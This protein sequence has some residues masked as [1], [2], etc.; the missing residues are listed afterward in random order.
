MAP[1]FLGDCVFR[2]H[3]ECE[4]AGLGV[5]TLFRRG[6]VWLESALRLG[7]LGAC[8]WPQLHSVRLCG[9]WLW[10]RFGAA[11]IKGRGG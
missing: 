8:S 1:P 4:M 2:L 11:V 5:R 3:I 6:P 9:E 10:R 7:S